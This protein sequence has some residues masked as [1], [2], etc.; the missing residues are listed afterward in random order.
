MWFFVQECAADLPF[1]SPVKIIFQ[2]FSFLQILSP[3]WL[4][5]PTVSLR[6]KHRQIHK[7]TLILKHRHILKHWHICKHWHIR[8]HWHILKQ[9]YILTLYLICPIFSQKKRREPWRA[10]LHRPV[11]RR[12]GWGHRG[13]GGD[14]PS[15]G[16]QRGQAG[17]Q[18]WVQYCTLMPYSGEYIGSDKSGIFKIVF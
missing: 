11:L 15:R 9:R 16:R 13:P 8:K 5:A 2:K 1:L 4:A 3:I 12:G 14:H 17:V 18:W 7:H 10:G 6:L